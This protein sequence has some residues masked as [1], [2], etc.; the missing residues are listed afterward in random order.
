MALKRATLTAGVPVRTPGATPEMSASEAACA[1]EAAAAAAA[2]DAAA[3]AAAKIA[4]FSA[5]SKGSRNVADTYS[6]AVAAELTGG[7]AA[8]ETER[9]MVRSGPRDTA[10]SG[11]T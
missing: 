9:E 7:E 5:P 6:S 3:S 11:I 1:A 10:L 4:G 2:R 8:K